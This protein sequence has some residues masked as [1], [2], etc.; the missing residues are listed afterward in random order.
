MVGPMH[1]IIDT[2][3][4]STEET[5]ILELVRDNWKQIGIKLF[6]RASTREVFRNR[7]GSGKAVLSMWG[8]LGYG[9]VNATMNP[10]DYTPTSPLQYQWPK[11]GL[12][13]SSDGKEGEKPDIKSGE[14]AH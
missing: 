12:F 9:L 7:V 1:M 14:P 5:D 2:A 8:G 4:E 3:G 6:P 10:R 13:G 11:W